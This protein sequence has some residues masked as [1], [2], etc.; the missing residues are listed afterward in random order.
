MCSIEL[1]KERNVENREML[2][3]LNWVARRNRLHENAF[4][5]RFL[6]CLGLVV[7]SDSILSDQLELMQEQLNGVDIGMFP[8]ED[9]A[10][11]AGVV[12]WW[13]SGAGGT[14]SRLRRHSLDRLS[15]QLLRVCS[16]SFAD[17]QE[18]L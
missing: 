8:G 5:A 2:S 15:Q 12:E 4:R 10:L 18:R 16:V 14:V 17:R 6:V 3:L 1:N 9:W 13:S 11:C 7:Y